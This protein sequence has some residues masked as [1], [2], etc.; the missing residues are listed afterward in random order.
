MNYQTYRLT[1]KIKGQKY[2]T[3]KLIILNQGTLLDTLSMLDYSHV[4][5]L[6]KTELRCVRHMRG[7]SS[8]CALNHVQ[9][10]KVKTEVK[11][12]L[13]SNKNKKHHQRVESAGKKSNSLNDLSEPVVTTGKK[14]Q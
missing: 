10:K 6:W 2:E 4:F 3:H 14:F 8:H 1:A 13:M 5:S 12:S 7:V 9:V 11:E